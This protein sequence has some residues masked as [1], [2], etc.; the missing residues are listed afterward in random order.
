MKSSKRPPFAWGSLRSHGLCV[1]LALSWVAAA[2]AQNERLIQ[3]FGAAGEGFPVQGG[4]TL[5]SHGNLFGT[6]YLGGTYGAGTVFELSPPAQGANAWTETVIYSFSGAPCALGCNPSAGLATD[7]SGNVYGTALGGSSSL[8]VVYELSPPSEPD[9]LWTETILYNFAYDQG[10]TTGKNP[11]GVAVGGHNLYLTTQYGGPN[12]G[13]GENG[14]G[15]IVEL[16]PPAQLGGVWLAKQIF[17]F[18]GGTVGTD[19][20][21]GGGALT[22]DSAGNLYGT[23][24]ATNSS[25]ESYAFVFELSPP[26]SGNG[27]WTES[28]IGVVESGYTASGSLVLDKSGSIYGTTFMTPYGYSATVF[29]LVPPQPWTWLTLYTFSSTT[30]PQDG[31]YAYGG[32]V[33]DSAGN[34]YGTTAAGGTSSACGSNGCGTVFELSPSTSV[35]WTETV[36]HS[37]A[38]GTRDASDPFTALTM[39]PAG[40]LYGVAAHGGTYNGGAAFEVV[41]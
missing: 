23:A 25:G 37:F 29:K 4:L 21:P 41:P 39:D 13:R 17:A 6:T 20:M 35:P 14:N 15:N 8:G 30:S 38:G 18:T 11:G 2:H 28:V 34:V 24:I 10:G 26:S 32:V 5:D 22:A 40:H 33:L 12:G 19:P 1:L 9:G 27:Q 31:W 16:R 7:K 36:L 3:S